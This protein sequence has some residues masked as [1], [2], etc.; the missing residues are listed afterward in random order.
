MWGAIASVVGGSLLGGIL[1][2]NAQ[3]DAANTAASA[4]IQ[5]SAA[6]IAEQ[7]RQFDEVQ[8]LLAPYIG[9]GQGALAGQIAIAGG[10]GQPAQ[11]AAIGAIEASPEFAALTKQGENAILANASATG[12]LRGG[13]VQGALQQFRPALLSQLIQQQYERLG[14]LTALGQ[15]SATGQ[16]AAGMQ[17][18][19]DIAGL[20]QNQGAAAAGA[21]LA[22]GQARANLYNSI[23]GTA[24]TLGTMKL[25]KIF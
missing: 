6:A 17:T 13:N 3:K 22:G 7:R 15:A 18:G 25:L 10:A 1:G 11:K 12:G 21:A 19:A 2:G 23:G 9:A 8:K 5:S 20:F 24:G 14:G 4:E 16:A